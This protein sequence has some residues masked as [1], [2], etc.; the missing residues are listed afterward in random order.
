MC[1]R[2]TL[3]ERDLGQARKSDTR[4]R[5]IFR[6]TCQ[7]YFMWLPRHGDARLGTKGQG[8]AVKNLL[9]LL[10]LNVYYQTGSGAGN[11]VSG[12]TGASLPLFTLAAGQ[13]EG[14]RV[15]VTVVPA[16]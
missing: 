5:P 11:A 1:T 3:A 2:H 16:R 6:G 13:Q 7:F 10:L 4:L 15:V 14:A 8:R 9:R 12:L